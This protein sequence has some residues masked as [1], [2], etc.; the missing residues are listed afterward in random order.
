MTIITMI[1]M[2]IRIRK[3]K[4]YLFFLPELFLRLK[5]P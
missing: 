4:N 2:K 1:I 5:F 3:K